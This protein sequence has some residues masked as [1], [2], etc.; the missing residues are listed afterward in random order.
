MT[1]PILELTASQLVASFSSRDLSPVEVLDAHL[2]RIDSVEPIVNAL[3]FVDEAGAVAAARAAESRWLKGTPEG[4][5]DG[6]PVTVKDLFRVR[7]WPTTY[8]SAAIDPKREPDEDSPSVARLREAGA[9]L[10]AKTTTPEF[11]WKGMT[12]SPL[13][14]ITRNPW[15]PSRTPGGSSGGAAASLAAGVGALALG[16]DGA[17]SMRIP[18]SYCGLY[19][20]KATSGKVPHHPQ[21]SPYPTSEAGPLANS[22]ADVALMLNEISRPDLRDA[23]SLPYDERDWRN[24]TGGD[25]NGLSIAFTARLGGATVDSQVEEACLDAIALLERLGA[26]VERVG[27]IFP[28]LRPQ[29]DAFWKGTFAQRLR[30]IPDDKRKHLDPR[31]VEIA[32]MGRDFTLA[33]YHAFMVARMRLAESMS[34]F[35]QTHDILVTPTTTTTAPPANV[36]WHTTAF[37]RWEHAVPFTLAFNLTGQPALTVPWALSDEGMPIGVQL[38]AARH[39]EDLL[40]SVAGALE[41]ARPFIHHPPEPG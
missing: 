37:D 17:G 1:A 15:D 18:G 11:G 33:D 19:G 21:P 28:P 27:T 23:F 29:F 3:A 24:S 22:V 31:L 32:A 4:A 9:V 8:G 41:R 39:R 30:S 38:V 12:D 5:L 6:V 26:R 36:V 7:G 14:G 2:R 10:L 34:V 20:L 35:H 25:I 16:T 40:L 13:F